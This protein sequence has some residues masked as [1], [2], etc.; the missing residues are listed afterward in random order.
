M[1]EQALYDATTAYIQT[2]YNRAADVLNRSAARLA[3]SVFQRRLA[4]STYALLR[5]FE[6]RRQK[7]A[8]L[9]EA[10]RSGQLT[11][12]KLQEQQRALAGMEDVFSSKTADEEESAVGQEE[13]EQ[14]EDEAL[15]GVS[16]RSLADLEVELQKVEELLDLARGVYEQKNESK[17]EKLR[18]IVQDPA[19]KHEKMLIFTEHRDTLDFL[20]R[21]LEGMGFAGQVARIHGGMN[22]RER[23]EQVAF[24]RTPI[25]DG[26]ATY[27]VATDA[28][29]EGINLQVCWLMVNYDIPW[30][31]ARLEQRMG[32]IHRFGQKHDAVYILNLIAG[33]TREGRVMQT[34]LEKLEAIRK[35]L[36]SDKVFD[37]I[38]QLFEN[39]SLRS[40]ME[41]ALSGD[42]EGVQQQIAGTLTKEQVQALQAAQ[43]LL[44][45]DGG[46]VKCELPRLQEDMEQ[47]TYRRLLPG[48]VRRFIEKAAPLVNIGL[49]GDLD[50][51]FAFRPLIPGSLDWLLPLLERYPSQA[52]DACTVHVPADRE[53]A[54]F[55][56]PGEPVFD[57]F[58]AYV[59]QH[60]ADAALGGAVFVDPLAQRPYFFHLVQVVVCRQADPTFHTLSREEVLESR[61]IGLKQ[62]Q[63][64]TVEECSLE[65]LLLL[66][67]SRDL[68]PSAISF[69]ATADDAC[70]LAQTFAHEQVAEQFAA[71][72]RQALYAD[73]EARKR[74][75]TSSFSYQEAELAESRQ[76]LTEKVRLGDVH[77]RGELTK[78]KLRQKEL[79]TRKAEALAVIEREPQLIVPGPI[80]FLAHALVV[81]SHDT[82]DKL[83]L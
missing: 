13:N 49:E 23:E 8:G 61:L 77:A 42:A 79:G 7:L 2:Y 30:N 70:A 80:T 64:G 27:L 52:R 34:L 39:M 6:R 53:Q 26:G 72:H 78:V 20:V 81:P 76:R 3:M 32:R 17:F 29:G 51:R 33:K 38:G 50:T 12:A 67:G 18:E 69:A 54:L 22:Y 59:C 4:S 16:A 55:L 10:M 82:E 11:P 15:G 35:E 73:M 19:Y 83:R 28:A 68:P 5:S 40:Y 65:Q 45:G 56:H 44:Y 25:A 24:F 74:F 62:D 75:L 48:Y 57:R 63:N 47:E 9:I 37:V 46:A 41:Q 14:A 58:R 1:S 66:R 60:F 43:Q 36:G 21:R 71:T 31:P